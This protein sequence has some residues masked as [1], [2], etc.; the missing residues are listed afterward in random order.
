VRTLR[1]AGLWF[2]SHGVTHRW[3][4]GLDA[5]EQRYEMEGGIALLDE[6]GYGSGER[7]LAYPYGGFDDVTLAVARELGHA[8]AFTVEVR[9]AAVDRDDPLLLPRLDTVDLPHAADAPRARF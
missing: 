9:V 6:L 3:F 2:G 8:L 5:T 7:V 4:D 1:R